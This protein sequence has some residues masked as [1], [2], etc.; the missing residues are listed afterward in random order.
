LGPQ[1]QWKDL[2]IQRQIGEGSFGKVYLAKWRETTV[3]VKVLIST[4]LNA[5]GD[6]DDAYNTPPPGPN[7]LLLSLEKVCP[8]NFLGMHAVAVGHQTHGD[9]ICLKL[10]PPQV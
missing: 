8:F 7:P 3:A 2:V 10:V 9:C 4:Q 6:E 5:G 1:V